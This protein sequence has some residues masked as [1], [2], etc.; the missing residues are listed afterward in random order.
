MRPERHRNLLGIAGNLGSSGVVNLYSA[1]AKSIATRGLHGYDVIVGQ[2]SHGESGLPWIDGTLSRLWKRQLS[3]T[4]REMGKR[5][6]HRV[7]IPCFGS[8][9][10]LDALQTGTHVPLVSVMEAIADRIKK[11][12]PECRTIGV[13]TSTYVMKKRLFEN[14]FSRLG[15]NVLYPEPKHQEAWVMPAIC[16]R[17]G[18]AS[19]HSNRHSVQSLCRVSER[20]LHQGADIIVARANEINIAA[21]R[22]GELG[23]RFIDSNEAYAAYALS[24]EVSAM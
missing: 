12:Y 18:T 24:E 20:L 16:C 8:Q 5:G 6:V 21:D 2:Y 11:Q 17:N 14:S 23:S 7:M 1:L 22:L 15:I 3:E 10:V 19:G 13:L 9:T 4:I